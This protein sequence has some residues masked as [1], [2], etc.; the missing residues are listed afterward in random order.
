MKAILDIVLFPIGVFF[1]AFAG[2]LYPAQSAKMRS[3]RRWALVSLVGCIGVL[4]AIAILAAIDPDSLAPAP[5][6]AVALILLLAFLIF[7]KM[8]ADEAEGDKNPDS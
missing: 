6:T 2:L 8:C 7:G 4:G 5:L 3:R 1:E